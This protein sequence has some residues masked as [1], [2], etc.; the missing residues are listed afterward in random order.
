MLWAAKA[1]TVASMADGTMNTSPINF[2]TIPTAA[3][4]GHLDEAVLQGHWHAYVED[5]GNDPP[6]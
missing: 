4:K 1:D 3:D 2:S 6:L 5:T